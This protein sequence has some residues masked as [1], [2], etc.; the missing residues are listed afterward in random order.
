MDFETPT[1]KFLQLYGHRR[2]PSNIVRV[3]AARRRRT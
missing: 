2:M 3:V 1:E